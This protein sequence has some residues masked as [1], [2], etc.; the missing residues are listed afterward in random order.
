LLP[1]Y[2]RLN[3]LQICRPKAGYKALKML[4]TNGGCR[5]LAVKSLQISTGLWPVKNIVNRPV[6]A[7][8]VFL[9]CNMLATYGWR[10]ILTNVS[11]TKTTTTTTTITKR[12]LEPRG[13]ACQRR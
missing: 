1:P 9:A 13:I 3:S 5:F 4:A 12:K 8:A 10:S 7:T 2:G 11:T 6:Y